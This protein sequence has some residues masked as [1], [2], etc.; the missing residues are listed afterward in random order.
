MEGEEE[1]ADVEDASQSVTVTY[2]LTV[3]GDPSP[4]PEFL[5]RSEWMDCLLLKSTLHEP[6]DRL[7]IWERMTFKHLL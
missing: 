3:T 4:Q 7:A 1:E 5:D 2:P 6:T